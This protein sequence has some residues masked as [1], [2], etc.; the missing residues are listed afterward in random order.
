MKLPDLTGLKK[1]WTIT[2]IVIFLGLIIAVWIL[3]KSNNRL[4]EKARQVE[5]NTSVLLSKSKEYK[6]KD[7]LN[8]AMVYELVLRQK[9]FERLKAED[10]KT[11][12]SLNTKN[13]KLE[14]I[15]NVNTEAHLKLVSELKDS[16]V[17]YKDS[18]KVKGKIITVRDTIKCVDLDSTFYSIKACVYH[19][20]I[21]HDIFIPDWLQVVISLKYKRFL[22]FLWH[23][24]KIKD[25][26][27]DVVSK[28]PYIGIKSVEF[29]TISN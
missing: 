8:A 28:N 5:N 12:A 9:D 18:L 23:T 21:S 19:N 20:S 25:K 3:S 6:T 14:S 10:A 27:C 15:I 13:R 7:S 11:I 1:Y 24:N 4:F 2:K 26:K 22:G 16:V 29:T 17:T